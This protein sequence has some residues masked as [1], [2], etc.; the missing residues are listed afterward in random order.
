M[1][2]MTFSWKKS[3]AFV[4]ALA[5]TLVGMPAWGGSAQTFSDVRVTSSFSVPTHATAVLQQTGTLQKVGNATIAYEVSPSM[6]ITMVTVLRQ[7]KEARVDGVPVSALSA[8]TILQN[9]NRIVWVEATDR[10]A[11]FDVYELDIEQGAR[12]RRF[13]DIFLGSASNVN[14]RVDGTTFYFEVQNVKTLTN[15]LPQVEILRATSTSGHTEAVNEMWRNQFE[16]IEDVNDGR[17]VTRVIFENGDQELWMHKGGVSRAIPDSYTVN[18]Y[19]LGTQFVGNTVEFFR[20]QRL[21]R[22]DIASW[23]TEA[24][25]ERLMW[26][27][28]IMAQMDRFVASDGA[29]FF[30][31]YNENDGRHYVMRRKSGVTTTISPWGGSPFVLNGTFVSFTRAD[32]F[33]NGYDTYHLQTGIH[34]LHDGGIQWIDAYSSARVV[35]DNAG[36]VIWQKGAFNRVVGTAPQGRAYLVDDTHVAIPQGSNKP[37]MFVTVR[38]QSWL[39]RNDATFAKFPGSTTVYLFK[40]GKRYTVPNEDVFYSWERDFSRVV[41]MALVN[42]NAYVDGGL[43]PY[44]P[45]T[46]IK[47][48]GRSTVYTVWHNQ[49]VSP[50]LNEAAALENHG[51]RWWLNVHNVSQA[52]MDRYSIVTAMSMPE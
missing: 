43:A 28:D 26:E 19:L 21:M 40:D 5:L 23:K 48:P 32:Q 1:L 47:A 39:L 45:G 7:N 35:V 34:V 8:R 29:L 17:V 42:T 30:V 10:P 3:G 16:T 22:Y 33:A 37:L 20:Y 4:L 6:A 9:Q 15:G 52:Q 14:V 25:S 18:G 41:D 36:R 12:V 50:I 11:R 27:R 46:M 44:A 13:D 2:L 49:Y 24:L 31:T 38:P 51:P